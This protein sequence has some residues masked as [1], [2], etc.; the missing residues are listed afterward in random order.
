MKIKW[1]LFVIIF[2]LSLLLVGCS[3]MN[4]DEEIFTKQDVLTE[5]NHL[6]LNYDIK[7]ERKENGCD[8][9]EL[10]VNN[11]KS[12]RVKVFIYKSEAKKIKALEDLKVLLETTN[13]IKI[14]EYDY[15]NVYIQYF[16]SQND[17]KDKKMFVYDELLNQLINELTKKAD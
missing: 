3:T 8:Y 1:F 17:N 10:W 14:K 6:G 9:V 11:D 2:S 16:S 12:E 15:Q 5:F 7:E 13:V 4:S